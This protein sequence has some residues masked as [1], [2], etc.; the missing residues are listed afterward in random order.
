[1]FWNKFCFQY[2]VVQNTE[3]STL[4]GNYK[5]LQIGVCYKKVSVSR[6]NVVASL[7]EYSVKHMNY[8]FYADSL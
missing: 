5:T 2:F 3:A 6:K 4:L 1:M 7:L 8:R